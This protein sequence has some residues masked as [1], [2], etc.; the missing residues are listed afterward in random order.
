MTHALTSG[1][2]S[3]G[4]VASESDQEIT[5]LGDPRS[6]GDLC[7][8]GYWRMY[9]IVLRVDRNSAGYMTNIAVL[10]LN[11]PNESVERGTLNWAEHCTA[12]D[13]R[14]DLVIAKNLVTIDSRDRGGFYG[15]NSHE[16][17]VRTARQ[18]SVNA[19]MIRAGRR[20]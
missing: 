6:Q 4:S 18:M 14:R 17:F 12:W 8:N 3:F 5:T 1:S 16:E 7:Y 9:Y 20:N 2:S 19:H 13:D 11:Q 10:N 15:Y